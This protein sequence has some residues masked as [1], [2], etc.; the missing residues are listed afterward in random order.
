MVIRTSAECQLKDPPV[1]STLFSDTRMATAWLVVRLWLGWTWFADGRQKVTDT[2]WMDGG[3]ALRRYWAQVTTEPAWGGSAVADGWYGAALRFMLDNGWYGWM[4]KAIAVGEVVIGLGL[5][6]G[7][8]TGLAALMGALGSFTFLIV[9][10]ASANPL[11]LL[12][13]LGLIGA[14][15]VAGYIGLDAFVLPRLGAPWRPGLFW[16]RIRPGGR[17]QPVVDSARGGSE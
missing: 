9:A 8:F 5:L 12:G 10:P 16:D 1:L 2:A 4:G 15:K 14:W 6:L 17:P 11:V 7:L 13:A 3:E